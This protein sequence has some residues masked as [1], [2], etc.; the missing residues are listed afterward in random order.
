MAVTKALTQITWSAAT[1]L[2]IALSSNAT[3]DAFTFDAT[4]I[5]ATMQLKS[6]NAGTPA[7]GD[8]V[9]F[10]LLY[11][12]GDV[13]AS[14]SADEYDTT[15]QGTLLAVL[16]TFVT[17][18]AITTVTINPS[19]KGGKIYAVNK[20]AARAAVVSAQMYETKVS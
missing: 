12:N 11:T 15:I 20:S 2:S 17:D 9:E 5:N 7:A 18:P 13:D 14:E 3:S 1:S 4:S 10:Y 19:A 8:T 16:D 6:D